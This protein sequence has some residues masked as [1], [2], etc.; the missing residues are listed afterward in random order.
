[1][2]QRLLRFLRVPPEP[3]PPPGAPGT[4]RV[5]R[6]ARHFYLYSIGL[7]GVTQFGGLMG[8]IIGLGVLRQIPEGSLAQFL[9]QWVEIIGWASYLAQL[10]LTFLLLRIDYEMR[11]YMITD[12]SLRIREGVLR[13]REKTMTYANIQNLKIRQGPLQRLLGIEDLEVRTAG[14]GGSETQGDQQGR[15]SM[16]VARFRGVTQ[17]E[18]IR[19]LIVEGMRRQR[20]SGLGDPDERVARREPR[21]SLAAAREVLLEA[22]ELRTTLERRN[23]ESN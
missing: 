10:P 16:H 6:A 7:W 2:K 15:D 18:E 11:W 3:D 4:L 22:R 21:S 14:G 12:R 1:V 9:F 19:A 23:V 13:I 8:L 20:D 5:F 17:A